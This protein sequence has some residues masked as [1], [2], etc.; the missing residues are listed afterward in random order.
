MADPRSLISDLIGADIEMTDVVSSNIE[1][2]G[3]R[4]GT[5]RVRFNSGAVWEYADV[6]EEVFDEVKNSPSVGSTFYSQVRNTYAA[7]RIE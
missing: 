7:T 1:A 3:W 2:V 6:P 4:N 5:M